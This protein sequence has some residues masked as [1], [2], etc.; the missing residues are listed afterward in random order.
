MLHFA[1]LAALAA[2]SVPPFAIRSVAHH[3]FIQFIYFFGTTYVQ[4]SLLTAF[5]IAS[6]RFMQS[7]KSTAIAWY[8]VAICDEWSSCAAV[9][10]SAHVRLI[11]SLAFSFT[12]NSL[13]AL[14]I[15]VLIVAA[16]TVWI[17]TVVTFYHLPVPRTLCTRICIHNIGWHRRNG[18][19]MWS[20]IYCCI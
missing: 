2:H 1:A 8:I 13:R 10:L 16:Y 3:S 17:N 19:S 9:L 7:I 5:V 15:C 12:L 4:I 18:F 14:Y 6:M 20:F 11:V